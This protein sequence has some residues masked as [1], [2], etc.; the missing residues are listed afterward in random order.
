[1]MSPLSRYVKISSFV[2]F[3]L[4]VS[5]NTR[6]YDMLRN[7]LGCFCCDSRS[8]PSLF[9]CV[10]EMLSNETGHYYADCALAEPS[11]NALID[12]DL[13]RLWELGGEVTGTSHLAV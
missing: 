8:F 10:E 5:S 9:C 11:P 12:S 3:R 6:S 2:Y 13:K 1:M 7:N 4:R